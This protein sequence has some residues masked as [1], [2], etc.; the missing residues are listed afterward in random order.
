MQKTAFTQVEVA[1]TIFLVGLMGALSY[2]YINTTTM[3]R[4]QYQST[5]Q[6]HF[7]LIESMIFQC[8]SLSNQFPRQIT[9]SQLA[10]NTLLTQLE[11][12]TTVPYSLNGG[13]NGFVPIPPTGF[14]AY[15]ATESGTTFYVMT[16]ADN[17]ST[18]DNAFKKLILNYNT[19]Q[20]TLDHNTTSGLAT[21][22]F[23]LSR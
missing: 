16:S 17:N 22:K 19:Q 4:I 1:L 5:L 10:S 7:N 12:N 3:A 20:A 8:K 9:T 18:Q 14:S 13:R 2:Y 21:F 15:Q 23:Y 6:S 11:C